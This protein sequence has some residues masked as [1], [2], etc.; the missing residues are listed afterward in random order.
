M[1]LTILY[2][3]TVKFKQTNEKRK[4]NLWLLL[5]P[6]GFMFLPKPRFSSCRPIYLNFR[7]PRIW[8]FLMI[9]IFCL[10]EKY[11]CFNTFLSLKT[12][13]P[14]VRRQLLWIS[15][16]R[17]PG[18]HT[19][20]LWKRKQ[21]VFLF[22]DNVRNQNSSYHSFYRNIRERN[23]CVVNTKLRPDFDATP[24][25]NETCL[26]SFLSSKRTLTFSVYMFAWNNSAL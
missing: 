12:A 4:N 25:D 3:S 9:S 17:H 5:S 22:S 19:Q 11:T 21:Q 1:N 24:Y 26:S 16:W 23:I 13:H 18:V 20:G 7:S 15:G 8:P 10:W 14:F 6:F 2:N